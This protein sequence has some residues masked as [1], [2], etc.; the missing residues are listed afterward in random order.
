MPAEFGSNEC[1]FTASTVHLSGGHGCCDEEEG[2]LF[3]A[4]LP[5]RDAVT[6]R[7]LQSMVKAQTTRP[8]QALRE[9]F[10]A[11]LWP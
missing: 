8:M 2:L 5:L 6:T 4:L 11:T 7:P 1:F 9:E 10:S 3:H